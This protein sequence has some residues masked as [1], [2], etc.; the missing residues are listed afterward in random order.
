MSAKVRNGQGRSYLFLATG[1]V[2]S[3][4]SSSKDPRERTSCYAGIQTCAS[5]KSCF[6]LELNDETEMHQDDS[7]APG[8]IR[9]HSIRVTFQVLSSTMTLYL[10][11]CLLLNV[12]STLP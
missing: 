8:D 11:P 3:M 10:Q 1:Q 12:S 7:T 2:H 4:I 9:T 5:T 6:P